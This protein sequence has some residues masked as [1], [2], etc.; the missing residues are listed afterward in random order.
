[1]TVAAR[2][3]H[4][5]TQRGPAALLGLFAGFA[6]IVVGLLFPDLLAG[7]VVGILVSRRLGR[8]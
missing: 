8:K 2:I 6:L 4:D 3:L 1:M 7:A 5:A